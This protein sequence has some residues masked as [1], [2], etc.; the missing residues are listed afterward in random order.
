MKGMTNASG[1]SEQEISLEELDTI[2]DEILV[3]PTPPTTEH[4]IYGHY[5]N[6]DNSNKT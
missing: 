6:C 5:S 1:S 3:P 2:L 4:H